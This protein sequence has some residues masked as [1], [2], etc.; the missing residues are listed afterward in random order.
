M[1]TQPHF[2]KKTFS[3]LLGNMA[4][5]DGIPWSRLTVLIIVCEE[6]ARTWAS[7]LGLSGHHVGITAVY[8]VSLGY[9]YC[10]VARAMMAGNKDDYPAGQRYW[11]L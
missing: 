11:K 1:S 6:D 10:S 8:L 9:V 7:S 2:M 3:V 4:D 5:Q